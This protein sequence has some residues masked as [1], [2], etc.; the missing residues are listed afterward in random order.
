MKLSIVFAL[1]TTT[2]AMYGQSDFSGKW[3]L[4]VDKSKFN[5]TPGTPAPQRLFVEQKGKEITLQRSD[6]PKETLKI[7]S[8]DD[9]EVIEGENKTGV[10]MKFSDDKK[11]IIETRTYSYPETQ[12][13]EV[14]AKKIRTW[15]LSSDKKTLT[16]KDHIETTQGKMFDMVLV[17]DRQ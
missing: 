9:L 4:N 12:T 10:L 2:V 14:A 13:A 7:D 8:P 3:K 11:G 15:S 16:I 5:E 6:R 17:Y 1:L